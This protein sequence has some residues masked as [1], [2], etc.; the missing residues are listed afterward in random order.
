MKNKEKIEKSFKYYLL[1]H[2]KQKFV[3][4][5]TR[6]IILSILSAFLFAYGFRAFT[7][8]ESLPAYGHLISGGE[9]YLPGYCSSHFFIPLN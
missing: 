9:W 3:Y 7:A 5:Y 6:D 1:D 8:P 2:P 4:E